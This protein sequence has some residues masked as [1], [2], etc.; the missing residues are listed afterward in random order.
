M[1]AKEELI[2]KMVAGNLSR[3][4]AEELR[5]L[6]LKEDRE[7]RLR[8]VAAMGVG[9]AA[10]LTLP[11]LLEIEVGDL[12]DLRMKPEALQVDREEPAPEARQ[13]APVQTAR[14]SGPAPPVR[15]VRAPRR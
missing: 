4:E 13:A 2:A 6:L 9:A 10:A 12:L 8:L 11:P 1:A 7:G 15:R 5:D 14:A 3:A